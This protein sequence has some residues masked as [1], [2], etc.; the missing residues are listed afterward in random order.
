MRRLYT[1]LTIALVLSA[2]LVIC[3]AADTAEAAP[4]SISVN[5]NGS[6][7]AV[8]VS[9]GPG[10]TVL[11]DFDDGTF[12]TGA[13]TGH[14]WEPGFY[15]IRAV[16]IHEGEW[17]VAE[18]HIGIYSDGPVTEV[19]R[20]EEYRYSVYNGPAPKLTVKDDSGKVVSW[21][22]Y[23][24]THRIVTGVPRDVG[25]YHATLTGDK[26]LQWSITVIEGPLQAPWVRFS[27]HPVN[28]TVIVDSLYGSSNDA[29]TRYTWTLSGLDGSTVG[30]SEGRTPDIKAEPGVYQ[31]SLKMMGVSGG[32]S[33]AQLIVFEGPEPPP[34]DGDYRISLPWAMFGLAAVAAGLLYVAT[35]DYRALLGA[36]LS[37]AAMIIMV[38]L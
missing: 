22:T 21:L 12:G 25:T 5:Q 33:Y 1:A 35:R 11:W 38:M 23:D 29:V 20:N 28:G 9:A 13:S 19:Q 3:L 7:A 4:V 30:I 34:K 37:V 6:Y 14:T 10:D 17:Q 31:L 8:S 32:A 2:S 27:A 24:A 26:M 16:I 36:I 18:K 15:T